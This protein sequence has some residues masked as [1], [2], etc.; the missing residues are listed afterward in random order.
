MIKWLG[1]R[2]I[3]YTDN[4]NYSITVAAYLYVAADM[5]MKFWK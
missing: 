4:L 3:I 5:I 1:T 2:K